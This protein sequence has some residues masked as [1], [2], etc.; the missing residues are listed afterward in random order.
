[1]KKSEMVDIV[2]R[3]IVCPHVPIEPGIENLFRCKALRVLELIEA[4]GMLPPRVSEK[5]DGDIGCGEC[6]RP[7][8]ANQWEPE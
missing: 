5:W 4:A 8:Y 1:M 2:S 7:Y 6:C 3:A